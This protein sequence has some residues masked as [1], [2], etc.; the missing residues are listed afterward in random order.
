VFE[1]ASDYLVLAMIYRDLNRSQDNSYYT[2][3]HDDYKKQYYSKFNSDIKRMKLDYDRDG[4]A[5]TP[6]VN[7]GL[8]F[9]G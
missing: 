6:R 8:K 5:D 4:V 9:T 7:R 2:M 1:L 3:K